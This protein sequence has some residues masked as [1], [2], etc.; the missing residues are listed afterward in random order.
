V[1]GE[2]GSVETVEAICDFIRSHPADKLTLRELAARSG[3]SAFHFQRTFKAAVGVTPRQFAE[4]CRMETLKQQ[5]RTRGSVTDAIYEAG[6][7]SSSR[8][9]E[10]TNTHLGMT[11]AQYRAGGSVEISYVITG[12]TL[13]RMLIGATSRGVCAVQ[14]GDSDEQ[15]RE[16]LR[17]E[18]PAARL[19]PMRRPYPPEFDQWMTALE[20]H[21]QGRSP[22][23]DLPLDLRASAFQ[24]QVW[25]YLRSIPAGRTESY[26]EVAAAIG[27]PKAARAVARACAGNRVAVV[28]PCHRVIRADGGPGGYRWGAERKLKL[29]KREQ[30]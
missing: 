12:S 14:F 16:S 5:L 3:L 10:R 23:I 8:V 17:E 22:K 19:R 9:Y 1:L 4:A 2:D 20:E 26:Q 28:I 25:E 15:L 7:G 18:Y 21:L 27:R 29:L 11:P 24:M 13:G 6:Y 30:Q